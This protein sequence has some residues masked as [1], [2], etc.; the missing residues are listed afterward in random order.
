MF[1]YLKYLSI[2]L[3]KKWT[4]WTLL[5]ISILVIVTV[6]YVQI[7]FLEK[8]MIK[9]TTT[10][11]SF[12]KM[13]PFIFGVSFMSMVTVYLFKD[14]ETDGTELIIVSKP[15]KRSQ[16]IISKFIVA[17]ISI[18]IFNIL[19]FISSIII[20]QYDKNSS[21]SEKTNFALSI[22]VGGFIVSLISSL[23]I[24]FFASFLGRVG[25]ISLG[26]VTAALFPV[27]SSI[28]VEVTRM[29]GDRPYSS[30]TFLINNN[31]ADQLIKNKSSDL[32]DKKFPE[33]E[34]E[35]II[36]IDL[37]PI[38]ILSDNY[39]NEAYNREKH[40]YYKNIVYGD[41]WHQ[42]SQF[43]GMFLPESEITS[44]LSLGIPKKWKLKYGSI[45]IPDNYAIEKTQANKNLFVEV[46]INSAHKF[47]I[48]DFV[49][50]LSDAFLGI[51]KVLPP[52]SIENALRYH[53]AMPTYF[54]ISN[55]IDLNT[56]QWRR[57]VWNKFSGIN[58]LELFT[59]N[60]FSFED[61]IRG[62]IDVS[63][64]P[65][66][67]S[68][69]S[70]LKFNQYLQ[71]KITL[72]LTK[73][74]KELSENPSSQKSKRLLNNVLVFQRMINKKISENEELTEFQKKELKRKFD[75]LKKMIINDPSRYAYEAPL[76][77]RSF[78]EYTIDKNNKKKYKWKEYLD[79]EPNKYPPGSK[80][81]ENAMKEFGIFQMSS[82]AQDGE[83]LYYGERTPYIKRDIIMLIWSSIGIILLFVTIYRYFR[84]DFK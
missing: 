79:S 28:V 72:A 9:F 19:M 12:T 7:D 80:K 82:I 48:K 6:I 27:M 84:K 50:Q 10:V 53:G 17:F 67:Y 13:I 47:D 18:V 60:Y 59:H 26:I 62:L 14:G 32:M 3:F 8:R 54:D 55:M 23:I 63:I 34:I 81:Y 83:I 5:V 41:I 44:T 46:D 64:F 38:N 36:N 68:Y 61:R 37:F 45:S 73:A 29:R 16:M 33:L 74:A 21:L 65:G 71:Y 58:F 31:Q 57:G 35:D 69:F 78:L 1:P 2:N 70:S 24:V 66:H 43:Y 11:N 76:K 77:E 20:I 40:D 51:H 4:I 39:L 22:G 56:F 25:T 42:W 30:S 75:F 49:N 15:I 52:T